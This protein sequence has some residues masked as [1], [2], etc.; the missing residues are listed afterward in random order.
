MSR[1]IHFYRDPKELF[2][3][4]AD[5]LR[6]AVNFSIF[7]LYLYDEL[8]NRVHNP[9]LETLR[10]PGFA[11]PPDF[12][13]EETITRHV[14]RC[15]EPVVI[16]S[17]DRETRFPR[18]MEVYRTYGVQSACLLPLATAH[19]RLG[20]LLFAVEEEN[21][22]SEDEVR[23]LSLVADHVAL[24]VD[25]ALRDEEQRQS[26]TEL[27][28]QKAHLERLFELAPEAIVLRDIENR[29]LRVN[30]EFSTLFGFAP[31][32][33][34]GRSIMELIV[35]ADRWAESE[36]MRASLKRG[37][38]VH[39]ELVRQRK[40]GTLLDVSLI[41]AP[42]S[43][44]DEV[45][46]IYAIYRDISE[47]KRAEA[48][49]RR[50]EAYLAEGQRLSHTG[51]WARNVATGEVFLSQE[52][53]RIFGLDPNGSGSRLEDIL[54][55][56]HP[57]DQDLMRHTVHRSLESRSDFECGYRIVLDDGSI[58]QVQ[59]TGHPVVNAAGEVVEFVGTHMDVTEQ[60][61][62]RA[63]LEKA[64]EEIKELRD[65]LYEENVALRREIDETAMFE[66]IVG[67]SEA[68]RSVL[69]Q[70][71]AI[72]PTDS[73][74]LI[75]G[76]TGTGKE[77]IARA[78]HNLSARRPNAFAKLNCASIPTG[79]LESELFGHE[80]GAF[81]GAIAQRI[82]RFELANRGTIFLDEVGEIPLELQPK[83]LR[84]LQEREFE[85]LGS[86]RTLRTDVR[87]IAATNRDLAIM[88]GE[89]R[90][91]PDLYYRLNVI[92]I[93]VPALR[94]R[95]EDVPLLVRHF[96]ELFSRRMNKPIRTIPAETMAALV[97]Y[98][99]PGNV[100]ELQNVIER[101]VILS[102]GGV[103]RVPLTDLDDGGRT[104]KPRKPGGAAASSP[105]PRDGT[106]APDRDQ[107]VQALKEARGQVG[108]ANGAA[109][110]LGMKRTT[111][112]AYMRR[113]D[114]TPRTVINHF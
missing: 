69:R 30:K 72:A 106:T 71:E 51:S 24:A 37:E 97:R 9:V 104:R 53:I 19:R 114:I 113:L 43:V 60:C 91:R 3:V 61:R 103:L 88:V 58:R 14:Y 83:L 49:L 64:L 100:R 107:I 78:I 15:G 80:K 21:G 59:A 39:A 111:L 95:P 31:E 6:T 48:A 75:Q 16:P 7:G 45:A 42:V 87:L 77:L 74:V 50:S 108:G 70:I 112:I 18:M 29:I 67:K 52:S 5:E 66:E 12:P 57:E 99:W 46:A 23:Y 90:F 8:S 81:T 33:A 82:G 62:S 109:A 4:L 54:N 73:T 41:A 92:P 102:N 86:S 11:L 22:Y 40:D 25:N 32:E 56:L 20:A 65:Q 85:R 84:V 13:A 2:R 98:Q 94:E 89:Q 10:G 1:A 28:K 35:P 110:R 27:R 36:A 47:R 101:A 96:A 26:E 79:L 38:R 93:R 105:S 17:R 68:L 63:A 55:R 44:G 34:I 76:E